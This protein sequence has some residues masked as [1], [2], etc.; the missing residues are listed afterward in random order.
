MP[1]LSFASRRIVLATSLPNS[2]M[3]ARHRSITHRTSY[4][5]TPYDLIHQLRHD[6]D[7]SFKCP[8]MPITLRHPPSCMHSYN[9]VPALFNYPHT[10]I[11]ADF[12]H[13]ILTFEQVSRFFHPPM[14]LS[15]FV[16]LLLFPVF[17]FSFFFVLSVV[18]SLVLCFYVQ[19]YNASY[20]VSYSTHSSISLLY[21]PCLVSVSD[22]PRTCLFRYPCQR[23]PF[24]LS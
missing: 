2:V 7:L 8:V 24:L 4:R 19:L 14:F 9:H 18:S 20:T 13:W 6:H 15:R 23:P 12:G 3:T 11:P 21:L 5:R 1:P 16:P 10:H 22:S 17:F